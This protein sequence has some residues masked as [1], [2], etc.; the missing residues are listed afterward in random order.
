MGA[1]R[2]IAGTF[3]A[4]QTTAYF[5]PGHAD[6]SSKDQQKRLRHVQSLPKGVVDCHWGAWLRSPVVAAHALASL[7]R[8]HSTWE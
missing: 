2:T 6:G 5:F 3:S 1:V 8:R 4:R 7:P